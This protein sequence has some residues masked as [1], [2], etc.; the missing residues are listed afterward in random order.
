MHRFAHFRTATKLFVA[1]IITT[2]LLVSVGYVGVRNSE[3]QQAALS[4]L[5][6]QE[7]RGISS[8]KQAS[9]LLSYMNGEVGQAL[10]ATD[11]AEASYHG[12]NVAAFDQEFRVQIARA[13]SAVVDSSSRGRMMEVRA[14][15][16]A[17]V[18]TTQR[19]I[20]QRLAGQLDSARTTAVEASA[21]GQGLVDMMAEVATAKEVLGEQ[22]F[23]ASSRAASS[24][25]RL[26]MGLVIGGALLSLAL[27][28]VVSSLITRP[29]DRTMSVLESVAA[30][31]LSREVQVVGTDEVARMGRALNV[32]IVAQR[33]SL[34]VAQR[35][36]A[37]S[38]QAAE[39]EAQQAAELRARVDQI[40]ASVAA[41]ANG[42][43]T[44]PVNVS[45]DDAIGRMGGAFESLL[46]DLRQSIA[47]IAGHSEDLSMA[48]DSLASVSEEMSA[49]AEETAA[50]ARTVSDTSQEVIRRVREID[51]GARSVTARVADIEVNAGEANTVAA[52]AVEMSTGAAA[53]IGELHASSARIGKVI[54]VIQGI[55]QQTNMLALNAAIEAAR[56]GDAGN[57]FAVVAGEVKSLAT[58][59]SDAT[60]EVASVIEEIQRGSAAAV[61][62]ISEIGKVIGR[63]R[64]LQQ[65]I[66]IAVK[67]HTAVVS[68][69]TRSIGGARESTEQISQGIDGVALAARGTS[70]GADHTQRA[71]QDLAALAAELGTLVSRFQ[72]GETDVPHGSARAPHRESPAAGAVSAPHEAAHLAEDEHEDLAVF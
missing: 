70:D 58:R 2:F 11:T 5:Q 9:I 32:A 56:A 22:A 40:L 67:E 49:T 45:G 39:R 41:A 25:R 43:L 48:S 66:T 17:F 27:G 71:A 54:D 14:G 20:A 69:M 10:L 12:Q 1:S 53:T 63:I 26:L 64:V 6:Q 68:D 16:D 7:M 51:D 36:S 8:V 4:Q 30:G 3:Q 65:G 59:T 60:H 28:L 50:Q 62:E 13:D 44:H 33:E 55:A 18:A 42:D 19:A 57:G 34:A 31:D 47:S 38:Q 21:V 35:A 61:S 23:A 72:I 52:R 29:L 37:E 15:Y 46:A 24:A